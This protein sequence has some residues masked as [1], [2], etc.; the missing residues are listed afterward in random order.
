MIK[1]PFTEIPNNCLVFFFIC[2][3]KLPIFELFSDV[4]VEFRSFETLQTISI[5]SDRQQDPINF[6]L[7]LV[8]GFRFL[9]LFEIGF[10]F[11]FFFFLLVCFCFLFV[12]FCF[13][14]MLLAHVFVFV[15]VFFLPKM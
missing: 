14:G 8:V 1:I 13:N 9:F 6:S 5:F 11:F 7:E 3:H 15:F 4:G 12:C 2:Y 10:F